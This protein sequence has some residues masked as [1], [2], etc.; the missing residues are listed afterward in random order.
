MGRAA[1]RQAHGS[2]PACT[3]KPRPRQWPAARGGVYP[4]VYGETAGD[5]LMGMLA[6]GLSP[7]VRGNPIDEAEPSSPW[8]SIPACTGKPPAPGLWCCPGR[9]YPRVYG[10]TSSL[11]RPCSTSRGLSPRVRGN[12][13]Y[14]AN[15][16]DI[17][18]SIPAC[19][20]K[21]CSRR[22]T[23]TTWRV[24]PRVYGETAATRP[25]SRFAT[26][27]S[28]RVRGNRVSSE[29]WPYCSWSIPACTGKPKS[30]ITSSRWDRVYP[31]VYGE[32]TTC[33]SAAPSGTGLS[34]RVRGNRIVGFHGLYGLGSIPACTGKPAA[35]GAGQ[36]ELRVYPRVYG[37]TPKMIHDCLF[38]LQGTERND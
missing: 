18:R 36:V 8:G 24:Y 1:G 15:G 19:T 16:I 12:P 6:A 31:R 29:L 7:R 3:G 14:L 22:P 32:T 34:P 25:S 21:P 20:G 23:R 4:R 35:G 10:E 33:P 30:T 13:L 5:W 28:P 9:V 27:L 11:A 26:G 37:E 38:A 17:S 2:I